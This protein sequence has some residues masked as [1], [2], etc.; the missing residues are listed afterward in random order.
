VKTPRV[1]IVEDEEAVARPL[2]AALR[3]EGFAPRVAPT[4]S[5]AL[6]ELVAWRPNAMVLDVMLPDGDGR[7]VCREVRTRS[8]IPVVIVTARGDPIDRVVGLELGA[9]D[10]VVKPFSSRE[11]AARLRAVLRRGCAEDSHA[12]LE[13]GPVWL[14]PATRTA[15]RSGETLRLPAREFDLLHLLLRHAGRVVRREAIMD[16]LW[17][18]DW[19]GSS[20]TLDVHIARLR[21]KIEDDPARPERLVTVRRVGFRYAAEQDEQ[22]S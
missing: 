3:R 19:F 8:D 13:V 11:V 21:D 9:D 18:A 10:Y 15:T 6:E 17:G 16:E 1:L 4:A 7:D 12:P 20:K 5:Q 2:A 22:T 14:D